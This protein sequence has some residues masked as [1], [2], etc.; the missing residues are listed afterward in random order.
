[1]SGRR[2]TN[3]K[4]D[5][6]NAPDAIY[7]ARCGVDLDTAEPPTRRPSAGPLYVAMVVLIIIV[8]AVVATFVGILSLVP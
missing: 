8:A 5:N 4:C 3:P 1:M 2:C 6:W 7:C